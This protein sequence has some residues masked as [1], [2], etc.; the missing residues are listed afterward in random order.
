MK[1]IKVSAGTGDLAKLLLRQTPGG[2]GLWGDCQFYVN[3]PIVYCDW[4]FVCHGSGLKHQESVIC[5]PRHIVYISMEP[6]EIDDSIKHGF[7]SQFSRLILC[8]RLV[9]HPNITYK[10]CHTWW[11]GMSVDRMEEGHHFNVDYTLDFDKLVC[12]KPP[13]KKNRI[14]VIVSKKSFM[15]GHKIRLNFLEKLMMHP[16]AEF[17][18]IYGDG[19]NPIPDKWD[20]ISPYK[21]HLVLENDVKL[22]Y[23]T[24][25]LS[26]AFLGFSFPI[27]HGCPNI[28]DYFSKKSLLIIDI[29]DVDKTGSAMMKLIKDDHFYD[30]SKSA[31][32]QSRMK[33]LH[34]YNIFQMMADISNEAARSRTK[35]KIKPKRFF[36]GSYLKRQVKNLIHFWY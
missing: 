35:C 21:Y 30:Y 15:I 14:S 3:K 19:F 22:D 11:V 8:D 2:L 4:W 6:N 1:I 7:L 18:D 33:I 20:A 36:T 34:E 16:V 25:K 29:N 5:D 10:N 12:M 24:E 17:I 27:Y 28:L 23:W 31:V 9:Q 13:E 26:D 32:E